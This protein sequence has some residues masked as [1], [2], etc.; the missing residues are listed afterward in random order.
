MY[1]VGLVSWISRSNACLCVSSIHCTPLSM[2]QIAQISSTICVQIYNIGFG[3]SSSRVQNLL[4]WP[5]FENVGRFQ[6][7]LMNCWGK[8]CKL[9]KAAKVQMLPAVRNIAAFQQQIC[10]S[11]CH[12]VA[13]RT[14]VTTR[15]KYW[16]LYLII[17]HLTE[18][19]NP[20]SLHVLPSKMSRPLY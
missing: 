16:Y 15:Y 12:V 1:F 14:R 20:L 6:A 11:T 2:T 19:H 7:C 18:H 8:S 4:K 9:V 5:T 13:P 17:V 10:Q 3:S